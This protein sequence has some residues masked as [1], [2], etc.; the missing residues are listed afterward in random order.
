[1]TSISSSSLTSF[2]LPSQP[3]KKSTESIKTDPSPSPIQSEGDT[4]I[5][6]KKPNAY[7]N[8]KKV[9]VD[10]PE[11]HLLVENKGTIISKMT[12]TQGKEGLK[13]TTLKLEDTENDAI[14]IFSKT[15]GQTVLKFNGISARPNG[16]KYPQLMVHKNAADEPSVWDALTVKGLPEPI[17]IIYTHQDGRPVIK[18]PLLSSDNALILGAGQL[19]HDL[20]LYGEDRT[21]ADFNPTEAAVG[22]VPYLQ[23]AD[24]P[25]LNEKKASIMHD[26]QEAIECWYQEVNPDSL[27]E[28]AAYLPK[29]TLH[30]VG[31]VTTFTPAENKP[32]SSD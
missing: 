22:W 31:V 4:F 7:E 19:P 5:K 2:I 3:P 28:L 12:L 6:A 10:T 16:K 18:V 23:Y 24:R 14:E 8:T 15:R 25:E 11:G 27:L 21:A 29:P 17:K 1:M 26:V 20:T 32:V 13:P 9:E 30:N